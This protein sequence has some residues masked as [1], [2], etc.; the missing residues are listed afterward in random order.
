MATTNI[1]SILKEH[2]VQRDGVWRCLQDNEAPIEHGQAETTANRLKN[3]MKRWPRLYSLYVDICGPFLWSG[4]H[5]RHLRTYKI[6]EPIINVGAGPRRLDDGIVNVDIL[7]F[8]EVDVVA[9]MRALPFYDGSVGG[10]I[11]DQVLEHSFDPSVVVAEASRVLVS[12]GYLYIGVPWIYPFHASPHD[13]YRWTMS[14]LE[15]LLSDFEVVEKG[16]RAG[17][18]S[19]VVVQLSYVLALITSFGSERLYWLM[20]YGWMLLLSPLKLG[21]VVAARLPRADHA[22]AALFVIARKK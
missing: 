6:K 18:C 13:Y 11:Y 3:A 9:D 2:C 17:P 4:R 12:G 20:V 10:L 22:A 16:V 7:P 19:A 8:K 14:G 5:P 15:N 21:D 1:K